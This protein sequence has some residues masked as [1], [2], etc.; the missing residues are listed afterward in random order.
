M[1]LDALCSRILDR[2]IDQLRYF[3]APVSAW[4]YDPDQP[5]RQRIYLRALRTLPNVS[6]HHGQ[7]MSHSKWRPLS[8]SIDPT[9]VNRPDYVKVSVSEEKG[10]DVNLAAY[11][12]HDAHMG[13]F[14]E[15][16]VITNDT[17]L[18]EPIRIV[19]EE[20][21]MP[22]GLISPAVLKGRYPHAD[23]RNVASFNRKL[24]RGDIKK[25]QFP[26]VLRDDVGEISKP[27]A[28]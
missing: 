11:L 27:S 28:W 15:A 17:D 1:N 3:T 9:G 2:P 14:D 25:S 4:P 12:I 16:A 6:V 23:L 19:V 18:V 20:I 24:R 26:D 10:S 22:V 8:D 21:G 5:E 13:R 7:F